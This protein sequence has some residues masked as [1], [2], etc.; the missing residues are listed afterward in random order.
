VFISSCPSLAPYDFNHKLNLTVVID[1]RKLVLTSI[2]HQTLEVYHLV[3]PSTVARTIHGSRPDGLRPCCRGDSFPTSF[4]TI[5]TLG[6]TFRDGVWSSSS[7]QKPRSRTWRRDL[8]VLR[9]NKSLE[10]SLDDV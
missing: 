5:R 8:M 4:L 9:V 3:M 6:R 1:S 7:L 2:W 10:E